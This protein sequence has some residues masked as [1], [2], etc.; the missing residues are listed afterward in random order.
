MV[1]GAGAPVR[2][3]P[4]GRRGV[5]GVL[6]LGMHRSGTSAVTRVLNLLG[7]E[8]GRE[9]DLMPP[10]PDNP[11]GYW[12]SVSLTACNDRLLEAMQATWRD[13]P[14]EGVGALAGREDLRREARACFDAA[15]GQRGEVAFVWKDPRNCLLAPFWEEVLGARLAAVVVHR[16]PLEVA[17][18]LARRDGI[19]VADALRL[20]QRYALGALRFASGRPSM[21]VAYN[22]ALEAPARTVRALDRFLSAWC[23]ARR[24]PDPEAAAASLDPALRRNRRPGSL[25][26]SHPAVSDAELHLSLHLERLAEKDEAELGRLEPGGLAPG[27]PRAALAGLAAPCEP[28]VGSG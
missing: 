9:D 13:P 10:H 11:A 6:V 19:E 21:T 23:V 2:R 17:D 7:L 20:W 1:S 3:D 16:N 4:E 24:P 8:L 15:Y 14:E 12:E 27:R 18:S 5:D 28:A 22:R 25:P 26:T